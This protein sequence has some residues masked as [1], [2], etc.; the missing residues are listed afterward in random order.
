VGSADE[1]RISF[2]VVFDLLAEAFELAG[3]ELGF[4]RLA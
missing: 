1:H 4:G 3:G 2:G